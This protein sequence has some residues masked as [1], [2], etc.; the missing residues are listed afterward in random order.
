MSVTLNTDN[1][2]G[3]GTMTI[4][5]AGA[6]AG[7]T[8]DS[9]GYVSYPANPSFRGYFESYTSAIS[10]YNPFLYISWSNNVTVNQAASRITVPVAGKYLVHCQ[11]LITGQGLY[12][13]IRKNGGTPSVHAY[14]S[15]LTGGV[16]RGTWDMGITAIFNLAANDYIDFYY[17]NTTTYTW[18]GSHSSV[19]LIK[20]A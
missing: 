9:G 10:N 2:Q 6:G 19:A 20:V 7:I 16:D 13:N 17:Q 11:Q 8:I 5:G 12:L 4:Y 1:I 18:T 14:T 3:S 15:G